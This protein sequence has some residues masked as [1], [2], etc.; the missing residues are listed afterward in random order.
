MAL[1][2]ACQVLDSSSLRADTPVATRHGAASPSGG[3]ESQS[4]AN[5][6]ATGERAAP[7]S[8]TPDSTALASAPVP[9]ALADVDPNNDGVVGPPELIADCEARLN[10]AGIEFK[11]A[12]LPIRQRKGGPV[13]GAEQAVVYQGSPH[14]IRYSSAP[15][16]T[17]GMA[18]AIAAFEAIVTEEAA[19]HLGK[20]V[21]SVSH[22]G[23]YSCRQMARFQTLV[24]EHSYANA[25]DVRSFKLENGR[26]ISV[27]RDFSKVDTAASKFLH[28]VAQRL[29]DEGVFSVVLTEY[30]DKLHRD[31]FHVDLARYRVDGTR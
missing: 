24:S 3:A 25:I 11:A 10:A 29:Y 26:V 15:L 7:A 23:T 4:A 31:H 16:L 2:L 13:C 28:A 20:R 18:L 14:G 5:K 9:A 6:L 30:F 21:V 17:C 19:R 8:A 27:L 12:K 1:G 22:A